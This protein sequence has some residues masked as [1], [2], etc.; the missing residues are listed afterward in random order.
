[1]D[2]E[3]MLLWINAALDIY[4][5]HMDAG[6]VLTNAQVAAELQIQVAEGRHDIAQW[7]ADHGLELPK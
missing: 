4:R 2:M 7:Y 3:Q 1:M 5:R 6:E